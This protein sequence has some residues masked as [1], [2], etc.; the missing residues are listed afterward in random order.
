MKKTALVTGARHRVGHA[1]C[2]AL[3][4]RGWRVY[5]HVRREGDAVADGAI[6]VTCELEQD[7]AGEVIFGQIDEPVG[8][9]VN[10]AALFEPDSLRDIDAASFDRQTLSVANPP[11]QA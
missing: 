3:V 1:I 5:G 9:L 2:S 8:L 11:K 6:A 10:N 7:D 4:E